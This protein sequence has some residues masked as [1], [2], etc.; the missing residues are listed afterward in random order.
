MDCLTYDIM[1]HAYFE[2]KEPSSSMK[3]FSSHCNAPAPPASW[4]VTAPA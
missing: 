2:T 4:V 3:L 1:I